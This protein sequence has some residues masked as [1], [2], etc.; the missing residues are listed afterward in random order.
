MAITLAEGDYWDFRWQYEETSCAQGSGCSSGRDSGVFRV[1]LGQAARVAGVVMYPLKV[2]GRHLAG[3]DQAELAPKWS[4]IGMNGSRMVASHGSSLVTIFDASTGE[5][6]GGGF[7]GR[8]DTA[9]E[10]HVGSASAISVTDPFGEWPGVETGPAIA[11]VRSDSQSL[12]EIIEGRRICPNDQS[13]SINERQFYRD[14][15]GPYAYTYSRSASF[16]GGGFFSSNS[17]SEAAAVIAS[18]LQG[19]AVAYEFEIEPN[20]GFDASAGPNPLPYAVI[21]SAE[22]FDAFE[23]L[24]LTEDLAFPGHDFYDIDTVGVS[25]ATVTLT[26]LSNADSTL[27]FLVASFDGVTL[28]LEVISIEESA[29]QSASFDVAEGRLYTVIV[30]AVTSPSGRSDYVLSVE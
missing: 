2:S 15:V 9:D 27:G 23:A 17:V 24:T 28:A 22:R 4:H 3:D 16:S 19:D 20:Q 30:G 5:W 29:T 11:V 6:T 26:A 14:G 8:F 1:E 18:S 21:G 12:C 13:F 7:F 10:E 25:R